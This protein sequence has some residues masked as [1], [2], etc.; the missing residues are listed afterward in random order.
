MQEPVCAW[1][2]IHG[3][4]L[5]SQELWVH[6][7]AEPLPVQSQESYM[8]SWGFDFL[9]CKMGIIISPISLRGLKAKTMID[10][11]YLTQS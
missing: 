2:H 3:I 11:K 9:V 10:V 1:K 6:I 5:W 8:S 4:V 7:L